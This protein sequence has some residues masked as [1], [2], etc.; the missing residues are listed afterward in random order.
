[1]EPRPL[2]AELFHAGVLT[3]G[4]TDKTKIIVAFHN[5]ANASKMTYNV[6]IRR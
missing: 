5:F 3:D 1:M 2:K 4:R 6:I